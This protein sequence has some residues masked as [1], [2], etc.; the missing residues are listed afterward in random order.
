MKDTYILGPDYTTV[1]DVCDSL[2]KAK[3]YLDEHIREEILN[4]CADEDEVTEQVIDKYLESW[5]IFKVSEIKI[6]KDERKSLL[7]DARTDVKEWHKGQ[8]KIARDKEY[9]E[10]LRLQEKFKNG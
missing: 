3:E 8:E 6:S 4:I 9:K 10:Y 1:W 2:E 5:K 7:A